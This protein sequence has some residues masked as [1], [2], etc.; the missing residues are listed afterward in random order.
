M[1]K[2]TFKADSVLKE[3]FSVETKARNFMVKLDGPKSL[4]GQDSG[5]TPPELLLCALGACHCMTVRGLAKAHGIEFQEFRLELEGDQN[6][7]GLF[8]KKEGL[9]PGLEEIRITTYIKSN[10]P[11]EKIELFLNSVKNTCPVND[12]LA[13]G[14][15]IIANNV[16]IA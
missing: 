6:P 12:T 14:T 8:I 1:A 15:S 11:K 3:G 16:V 10:A 7:E 5:M 13:N 4:G 2:V 9:R